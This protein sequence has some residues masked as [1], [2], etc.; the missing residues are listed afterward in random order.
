[1]TGYE[2]EDELISRTE[3]NLR[4]IEKLHKQ[5]V[6]VYEVTQLINSL[7][8]LLVYP[9]E[10]FLK[11][12]P[13]ISREAMIKIGWPLPVERIGQFPDLRELV[14]KLRNGIAH[15]NIEFTTNGCEIEGIEFKNFAMQDV[16]KMNPLWI[17]VY[18]IA[19]L[20]LFV[21]MFLPCINSKH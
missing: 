10:A 4:A 3:T 18:K 16:D 2:L 19:Q 9:R 12:I 14:I 21:D 13:R 7:L 11:R 1:M 17:G 5:G 20:R 8:G 15:C 6:T